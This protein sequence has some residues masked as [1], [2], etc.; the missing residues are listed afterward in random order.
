MIG[1]IVPFACRD[2][3]ISEGLRR[4]TARDHK[5]H[6]VKRR[7]RIDDAGE[8]VLL[9]PDLDVIV[10]REPQVL[11]VE[12]SGSFERRLNA[13][14]RRRLAHPAGGVGDIAVLKFPFATE[15]QNLA[16]DLGIVLVVLADA[17]EASDF[18]LIVETADGYRPMLAGIVDQKLGALLHLGLGRPLPFYGA[19]LVNCG[20]HFVALF[21]TEM[22]EN[23]DR[24][25]FARGGAIS[26]SS[27]VP[28]LFA[29]WVAE[30]FRR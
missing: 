9:G 14:M 12:L 6:I 4:E 8:R 3:F 10:S 29:L 13:V 22:A 1:A 2:R 25:A 7:D 19:S 26:F 17:G 24:P 18:S 28:P 21:E 11:A 16:L 30:H 5:R 27:S 15:L 23:L 20:S